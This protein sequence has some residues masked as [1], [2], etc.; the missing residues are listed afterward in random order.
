M[1]AGPAVGVVMV[2][3][4]SAQAGGQVSPGGP[5]KAPGAATDRASSF[6]ALVEAERAFS[7]LSLRIGQ[8]AAFLAYFGDEVVT[9]HPQPVL[10]KEELRRQAAAVP[11]PPP[12]NLDWEPWF[13]DVASSGDLGYTTGPVLLAEGATGKTLFTGWYFSVW[14]KDRG[15]WHVA[16]DIGVGA[17]PVGPLRPEQT[18]ATGQTPRLTMPPAGRVTLAHRSAYGALLKAERALDAARPGQEAA[19]YRGRL[20]AETRLYRDG[21][22]PVV[23]RDAILAFLAKRPVP[24]GCRAAG[25]EVASSGDLGWSYGTCQAGPGTPGT[26]GAARSFVRVWKVDA[27]GWK[28]QAEVIP[29]R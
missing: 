3:A 19:A 7:R 4:L 17:P 20:G 2:V 8:A 1:R 29:G 9:F 11:T 26:E 24:A 6:Q 5:P 18:A 14:Q 21:V 25:V 12:R 27:E 23:G 22:A 15:G 13:A 10:G 28:L 16:A